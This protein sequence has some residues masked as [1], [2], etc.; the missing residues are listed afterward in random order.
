MNTA[1]DRVEAGEVVTLTRDGRVIAEL[2]S[3]RRRHAT[4]EERM[5]DPVWRAAYERMIAGLREGVDFG[6]PATY[7]ERT[8]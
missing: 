1:I 2:H 4:R 7:G 3:V 5:G 6:G 8:E